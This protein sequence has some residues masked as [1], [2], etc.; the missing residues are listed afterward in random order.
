MPV[1]ADRCSVWPS[2]AGA[3]LTHCGSPRFLWS[4]VYVGIPGKRRHSLCWSPPRAPVKPLLSATVLCFCSLQLSIVSRRLVE[5][6]G[7]PEKI[8]EP[9]AQGSESAWGR[10]STARPAGTAVRLRGRSGEVCLADSEAEGL[11]HLKPPS[12]AAVPV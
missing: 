6:F 10:V 1:C 4:P 9:L 8:P 5:S 12:Q 2:E 11:S 3:G 7:K